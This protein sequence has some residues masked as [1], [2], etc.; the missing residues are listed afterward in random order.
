M[1][2]CCILIVMLFIAGCGKT[3]DGGTLSQSTS[4]S[5][6]E[7]KDGSLSSE[8]QGTSGNTSAKQETVSSS[9]TDTSVEAVI[10]YGNESASGFETAS[11]T[12]E[13]LTPQALIDALITK[14]ALPEGIK[15]NGIQY[16]DGE[17]KVTLDLSSEFQTFI[18]RSGTSGEYLAVGAVV[19]TF[20]K[21]YDVTGIRI[22][23]DGKALETPNAG[24]LTGY[25]KRYE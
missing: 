5:A 21:A 23:V 24:E 6:A 14:T 18:N 1:I 8:K 17:K 4:S 19:N 15:A 2:V 9:E 13:H 20:L 11:V 7:K 16:E 3:T 10:Y 12:I 25:L 22:T